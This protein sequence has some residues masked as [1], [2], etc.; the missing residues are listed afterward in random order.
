MFGEKFLKAILCQN[1]AS[2]SHDTHLN[3][4]R[5]KNAVFP[6]LGIAI[7][8]WLQHYMLCNISNKKLNRA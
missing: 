6:H 2:C 8:I 7:I 4:A 3:N 1:Y 5:L